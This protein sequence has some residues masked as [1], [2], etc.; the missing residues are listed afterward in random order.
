MTRL[1]WL[2]PLVLLAA[3]EEPGTCVEKLRT[4][5]TRDAYCFDV[6]SRAECPLME[7]GEDVGE[8]QFIFEAGNSCK[9]DE[10]FDYDC[11][12]GVWED[13]EAD[14]LDWDPD[15]QPQGG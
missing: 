6:Q 15:F 10:D 1:L 11:G 2:L 8:F 12:N 14:C 3:C 9:K 13:N 7:S 4:K 5:T